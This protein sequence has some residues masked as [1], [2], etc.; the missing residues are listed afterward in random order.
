[1]PGMGRSRQVGI[2]AV[3]GGAGDGAYKGGVR[4][5]GAMQ[6]LVSTCAPGAGPVERHDP[7]R[8]LRAGI[9]VHVQAAPERVR[10]A[11]RVPYPRT[12]CGEVARP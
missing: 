10:Q 6:P 3:R 4:G 8:C 12:R 2:A 9:V 5:V 7:Q 1:M 11:G